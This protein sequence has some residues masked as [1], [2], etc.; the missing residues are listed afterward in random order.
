MCLVV[1]ND[2]LPNDQVLPHGH[3]GVS[4]I[5]GAL[6]Q[7]MPGFWV[8]NGLGHTAL[9]SVDMNL[10]HARERKDL[11]TCVEEAGLFVLG[12]QNEERIVW[13]VLLA[14]EILR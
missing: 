14:R 7:A 4:L 3:Q 13:S 10:A 12:Y 5:C 6:G 2:P 1:L 11:E 8:V 9:G